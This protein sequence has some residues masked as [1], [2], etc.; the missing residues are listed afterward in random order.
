[1]TGFA[2]VPDTVI[3]IKTDMQ[4]NSGCIE[5]LMPITATTATASSAVVSILSDTVSIE[6]FPINITV[7]PVQPF[8]WRCASVMGINEFMST[9]EVA[10]VY[11]N[12]FSD[13]LTIDLLWQ[14]ATP[15]Q[16]QL[17]DVLGKSVYQKEVDVKTQ[18]N[19]SIPTEGLAAGMYML[20][21]T[22]ANGNFVQRQKVVKQ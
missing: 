3:V 18:N 12:P 16:L 6:I 20:T 17:T 14:S 1:M 10:R 22:D 8:Y 13:Q 11:P 15:M 21:L 19:F 2:S 7:T 4:G 5:Q 9:S